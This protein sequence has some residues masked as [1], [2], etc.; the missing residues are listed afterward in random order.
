MSDSDPAMLRFLDERG[1]RPGHRL[2]VLDRQPFGG[3][4][5]LEVE[6]AVHVLGGSLV[7][8]MRVELADG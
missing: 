8:A 6:G 5:T 7:T 2:V 1:V 4:L 3:P